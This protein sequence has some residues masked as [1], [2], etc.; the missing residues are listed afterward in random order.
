MKRRTHIKKQRRISLQIKI[1]LVLIGLMSLILSGYGVYSYFTL[2]TEKMA[3]LDE[4]ADATI[5]RL[6][7]NLAD[8]VWNFDRQQVENVLQTEMQERT[9][10]AIVVKTEASVF[11]GTMRNEDWQI[12]ALDPQNIPESGMLRT[13]EIQKSNESVGTVELYLTTTFLQ[14]ELWRAVLEIALT[15][16]VLDVVVLFGLTL[17]VR[18]LLIRPLTH[19][20]NVA[21]GMAAG[22]FGQ[23]IRIRQ[24]DE[25]GDFAVAFQTMIA[26]LTGV[27]QQVQAAVTNVSTGSQQLSSSAASLSQGT[28]QQATAIEEVSSAMEEM[29]ANI[30][31]NTDNALQTEQIA[32]KASQD[33]EASGKIV[34]DTVSAMQKIARKI[35]IIEEIA[36]Q[37]RL[38]SLNATIEAARAQEH[39]KGFGVVAAEVRRL[40]DQ[41]REAAEEISSLATSS[42]TIAEQAGTMLAKLVPD[43]QKTA[44]L[45]QDINAAGREQNSGAEQ[46]NISMQQLDQVIQSNASSSEELAA[47]AEELASQ[48]EQLRQTITFFKTKD[49][50]PEIPN[51]QAI[52]PSKEQRAGINAVELQSITDDHVRPDMLQHLTDT[53]LMNGL[54]D[55]N[56]NGRDSGYR[57]HLVNPEAYK[58][59]LDE[60]F[61]RF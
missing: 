48:A 38:L 37:T 43:I 31:Q 4:L 61:E 33:A 5:E 40:A 56:G 12:S 15:L 30:R 9:V 27:V 57:L 23:E 50:E 32:L 54:V 46:I 3:A 53:P 16:I 8:P 45:V 41:S 21:N 47:T 14:A 42:V 58:D 20:L 13:Q 55:S 36:G 60:E 35:S 18:M 22:D 51:E 2:K 39:G 10:A 19:L 52:L 17:T 44:E 7:M 24:Q 59:D 1:G 29:A 26:R 49:G 34:D 11:A 6:S 25:L 28:N